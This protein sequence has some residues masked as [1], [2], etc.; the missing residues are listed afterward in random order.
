MSTVAEWQGRV[1]DKGRWWRITPTTTHSLEERV[2]YLRD[3]RT[4]SNQPIYQIRALYDIEP[5]PPA[6]SAPDGS[7]PGEWSVR[8][9]H[10]DGKLMDCFIQAPDCQGLPYAAEILGDD[11]YRDGVARKLADCELIV[12]LVNEHRRRVARI[13]LK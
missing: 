7:T 5:E 3:M 10:M 9:R 4:A 13:S 11:E 1:G 2:K 6:Q 8:K 12:R